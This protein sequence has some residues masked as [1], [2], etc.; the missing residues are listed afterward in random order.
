MVKGPPAEY[1]HEGHLHF[2]A[3]VSPSR[4]KR[5]MRCHSSRMVF[6][7]CNSSAV[8]GGF[9]PPAPSEES[10]TAAAAAA[11]EVSAGPSSSPESETMSITGGVIF[12]E[13]QMHLRIY[14]GWALRSVTLS[15][16]SSMTHFLLSISFLIASLCMY[17]WTSCTGVIIIVQ[18]LQKQIKASK[19][20]KQTKTNKS[21][22]VNKSKQK[23]IKANKN[24]LT[25]PSK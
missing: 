17:S 9:P 21:Q 11:D 25:G 14:W 15:I 12:L 1:G 10:D 24:K 8:G 16:D 19:N 20:N 18:L 13:A 23:P 7:T 5:S 3:S 6:G 2:G 22:Q 4:H